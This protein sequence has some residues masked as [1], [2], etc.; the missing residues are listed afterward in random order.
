MNKLYKNK[1]IRDN[2]VLLVII[3]LLFPQS[4]FA[5][6][7]V[8]DTDNKQVSRIYKNGHALTVFKVVQ[9]ID[10]D[11]IS[12]NM[13]PTALFYPGLKLSFGLDRANVYEI[14]SIDFDAV[15]GW[16]ISFT[17]PII[18][19]VT[20][21]SIYMEL[22]RAAG[23][24]S[25][26]AAS[27]NTYNMRSWFA[28]DD[29]SISQL[30][31]DGRDEPPD[32]RLVEPVFPATEFASGDSQ[33]EFF[34]EDV[35]IYKGINFDLN[36][37]NRALDKY[38]LETL[39][40]DRTGSPP[41]IL[42]SVTG[43][44]AGHSVVD[45]K[46]AIIHADRFR[47]KDTLNYPKSV[48]ANSTSDRESSEYDV[49]WVANT[50]D[51]SVVKFNQWNYRKPLVIDHDYIGEELTNFPILVKLTSTNFSEGYAY[52]NI[53][54]S[55]IRFVAS[56]GTPLSYQIE[57]WTPWGKSFI[58]VKIPHISP[59][60]DTII[61]MYYG[62]SSASAATNTEVW[63]NGYLM[64]Q[65]L[66]EEPPTHYDSSGN[67]NNSS[68]V[69]VASPPGQGMAA[70]II[71]GA[72][73]FNSSVP[74]YITVAGL[75]GQLTSGSLP[76]DDFTVTAWFKPDG[77][78]TPTIVSYTSGGTYW[79]G[80]N[81]IIG[82][83]NRVKI[84]TSTSPV[85]LLPTF[86]SGTSNVADGDWHFAGIVKHDT[87]YKLFVDDE[88]E[89]SDTSSADY[90]GGNFYI[91]DR[92]WVMYNK[93]GNPFNGIIDEITVSDTARSEAWLKASFH[94]V[95]HNDS[96]LDYSVNADK[97]RYGGM[98]EVGGFD[99]PESISVNSSSGEVWVA[100]TNDSCVVK[101]S[102]GGHQIINAAVVGYY[103]EGDFQ[104]DLTDISDLDSGIKVS[105][106]NLQTDAYTVNEG[107]GYKMPLVLGKIP[108]AETLNNFPV[109]V[110]LTSGR[111]DYNHANPDGSD[112]RFFDADGNKLSYEIEKWAYNGDSF[113]WVKVPEISSNTDYIW[114]YYGNS[115]AKDAQDTVNVWSNNYLMVQHLDET[116]GN[117][118][119]ST[120]K[121]YTANV[122]NIPS[123]QQ[124]QDIGIIDGADEF[125][126]DSM[127]YLHVTDFS[128]PGILMLSAL[129]VTALFK[130]DYNDTSTV[131][132]YWRS[133]DCGGWKEPE[134]VWI[135][136]F[137][138]FG[139]QLDLTD[140]NLNLHLGY[141]NGPIT[142]VS[143]DS[144]LIDGE[145]HFAGM[146]RVPVGGST[147]AT[148]IYRLYVD[149][150]FEGE[151]TRFIG[152]SGQDFRIGSR[153]NL[154]N[155][156]SAVPGGYFNG[157][158]DE[159]RI[160]TKVRSDFWMEAEFASM[161]DKFIDYGTEEEN[162]NSIMIADDG[163]LRAPVKDGAVVA[164]E[165]AR[166]YGFVEPVSVSVNSDAQSDGDC[167]VADKGNN[168]VVRLSGRLGKYDI[169]T[170]G[171]N[172]I[173]ESLYDAVITGFDNPVS[174][175]VDP[176]SGDCWVACEGDGIGTDS[177][178]V[179]LDSD[180]KSGYNISVS[181]YPAKH[182]K[183]YGFNSPNAVSVDPLTGECYVSD[184]N[185]NQIV[186]L[187][188][189]SSASPVGGHVYT[190]YKV[191]EIGDDT[192]ILE[193][194]GSVE[195]YDTPLYSPLKISFGELTGV[196][197]INPVYRITIVKL[198]GGG[199]V[200]IKF[201]PPLE[202]DVTTG[203]KVNKELARV[204]GFVS[205]SGLSAFKG[206]DL[207]MRHP[208]DLQVREL[209]KVGDSDPIPL[210]SDDGWK[211]FAASA[212]I[213]DATPQFR[214]K[215]INV[216]GKAYPLKSYRIEIY[217][218][219]KI[220]TLEKVWDSDD[221][222]A[223]GRLQVRPGVNIIPTERIYTDW[224]NVANTTRENDSTSIYS[225]D[226]L[227]PDDDDDCPD[228]SQI[229]GAFDNEHPGDRKYYVRLTVRDDH[230]NEESYPTEEFSG[231]DIDDFTDSPITFIL[232]KTPPGAYKVCGTQ[233]LVP[234]IDGNEHITD[235][236]YKYHIKEDFT[237]YNPI[238][239]EGPYFQTDNYYWNEVW[240]EWD[241]GE[242]EIVKKSEN[243]VWVP[244]K[245]MTVRVKVKDRNNEV[246]YNDYDED[247]VAHMG[248]DETK[249][250]P[251][252]PAN[253]SGISLN[254]QYRVSLAT[255]PEPREWSEWFDCDEVRL[256]DEDALMSNKQGE[257]LLTGGVKDQY[258]WLYAKNVMLEDGD[259]NLIQFRVLDEG[260]LEVPSSKEDRIKEDAD[261]GDTHEIWIAPNMG[262]SH[263]DTTRVEIELGRFVEFQTSS[264][265]Y[266]YKIPVDSNIP[267]VILV[268]YPSN[269]YPH[270]YASFAW[271][272]I[273]TTPCKFKWRL[274]EWDWEKISGTWQW[275][276]DDSWDYGWGGAPAINDYSINEHEWSS[277]AT[278]TNFT[279]LIV[280]KWYVFRIKA[281]DRSG[282]ECGDVGQSPCGRRVSDEVVWVW[283]VSPEVPDTIITYGPSGQTT[284]NFTFRWRGVGGMP[285]YEYN[286]NLKG[287]TNQMSPGWVPDTSEDFTLSDAG[288]YTFQ[289][290]AR[291]QYNTANF[292]PTPAK[293]TF[294]VIDPSHP[295][296]SRV[297]PQNLYKYFRDI[298]E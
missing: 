213:H 199:R 212:P 155:P 102:K 147:S 98:L 24:E 14:N 88:I 272:A 211:Y 229:A 255:S 283:Y 140:T 89:A 281:K 8:A 182:I 58:W 238:I 22:V 87:E 265:T 49:A 66:N 118:I 63:S 244:K 298:E 267:Q 239:Y 103:N 158:I 227:S 31:G 154:Y 1:F 82:N 224:N 13:N 225:S 119:D 148:G 93:V 268:E 61:Y 133:W 39:G 59:T 246:N 231:R 214:W 114:L 143:G 55:D 19:D 151:D 218:P 180:V 68:T 245:Q 43:L 288:T 115:N 196:T 56:D 83:D 15:E 76:E 258:V 290:R 74:D 12:V 134:H 62:N 257:R 132:S 263:A 37:D 189:L 131:V 193:M 36:S 91:G 159:I 172:I 203:A 254:A 205:P 175:S 156:D 194:D 54:G 292:D 30:S 46:M 144:D 108:I 222:A 236:N 279:D 220:G 67:G 186:R 166:V 277:N 122:V 297:S 109:L 253:C 167:W 271:F 105:F 259:T 274:E 21:S 221:V 165:L 293:R 260:Y 152:Y 2:L 191:D 51:D 80:W 295:P 95:Y 201:A 97:V 197:S 57:R 291:E 35:N 171:Y 264:D 160:S 250:A 25:P 234:S 29:G 228:I 232:D 69:Q 170:A 184:K 256:Y 185:N 269:P 150:E 90:T 111:F 121:K 287:P 113:I 145:W 9:V 249:E 262:Y 139:W 18:D 138:P 286:W 125:D 135:S 273:D 85:H 200:E 50:D 72:D 41:Y 73:E 48:C 226:Y 284:G 179:R 77:S 243:N 162:T 70:G 276:M 240:V 141:S 6:A 146:V 99:S 173:E 60:E 237:P 100:D 117:H 266:G 181:S 241:G 247:G 149:G 192:A 215:Y 127:S 130:P 3:G 251:E 4:L 278:S 86:I 7:W 163:G 27:V 174:V 84:C 209:F 223:G 161:M 233:E 123:S 34:S 252:N 44:P 190:G 81:L 248:H 177:Y 104:I 142:V 206:E 23:F 275:H 126:S 202:Q 65:H 10:P 235:E 164:K 296:Y 94:A 5:D 112:I 42:T 216:S 16:K 289:V 188:P 20:G 261:S 92:T 33:F 75:K 136:K 208:W 157:I 219:N 285:P 79:A 78:D 270:T 195:F 168:T 110:K 153:S 242:T 187:S 176:L 106:G 116:S 71:D 53:D 28:A 183:V 17:E 198:L 280:G 101:L 120:S 137:C 207:E 129:T 47:E 210:E 11:V 107:G 45:E 230:D 128:G 294:T 96:F 32:T 52:T 282:A 38:V 204:G 64:V 178:I 217:T 40:V 26:I 124:G 169:T